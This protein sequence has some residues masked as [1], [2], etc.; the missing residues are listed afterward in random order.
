MNGGYGD[1]GYANF[2]AQQGFSDF[3]DYINSLGSTQVEQLTNFL[4]SYNPD[5]GNSFSSAPSIIRNI[6]GLDRNEMS[7]EEIQ[8]LL[9]TQK[10][11][12]A[13]N[14]STYLQNLTDTTKM[15]QT[16]IS[17][18]SMNVGNMMGGIVRSQDKTRDILS[19]IT[20]PFTSAMNRAESG[21]ESSIG[22]AE[23]DIS[24]L[25][26]NLLSRAEM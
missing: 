19:T 17:Q 6:L 25:V 12:D 14:P 13:L 24:N 23:S 9:P 10:M 11:R 15:Y 16:G 21:I 22:R 26:A 2:G 8:N 7:D 18:E 4:S 3:S 1:G 20:N 5:L